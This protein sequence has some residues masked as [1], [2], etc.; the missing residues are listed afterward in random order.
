M[1]RR[2]SHA[3]ERRCQSQGILQGV[4]V[5]TVGPPTRSTG[6]SGL[7][8]RHLVD[9]KG[10]RVQTSP[11]PR[12]PARSASFATWAEVDRK[13]RTVTVR[14]S[15][16]RT[17]RRRGQRPRPVF[18]PC[19]C[20]RRCGAC[21]SSGRFA[22]CARAARSGHRH[23][24]LEARR[25]TEPTP[26]SRRRQGGRRPRPAGRALVVAFAAPLVASLLATDLELLAT[27]LAGLPDTRTPTSRSGCT[28]R[29]DATKKR[30]SNTGLANQKVVGSSP[31]L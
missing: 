17:A 24:G 30:S 16:S 18:G 12:S 1:P 29:N 2:L 27:T 8:G 15:R 20:S 25:G 11:P 26:R 9:L 19:P 4:P 13:A 10:R 3:A 6:L 23:C 21:S 31:I 14:R 28:R 5:S 22:L 7:R